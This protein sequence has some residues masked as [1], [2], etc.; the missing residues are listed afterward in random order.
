VTE[1]EV[2]AR[3]K[4]RVHEFC[5]AADKTE[6]EAWVMWG[7]VEKYG[8]WDEGIDNWAKVFLEMN[9]LNGMQD[10]EE[11]ETDCFMIDSGIAS[12]GTIPGLE[13]ELSL[14]HIENPDVKAVSQI[15]FDR[16]G[17]SIKKKA[18]NE[19]EFIATTEAKL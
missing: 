4:P 17:A 2:I 8:E 7:C 19:A 6:A 1:D 13:R 16:G 14:P 18:E 15:N 12:A 5:K 3:N 9:F 11:D 10:F